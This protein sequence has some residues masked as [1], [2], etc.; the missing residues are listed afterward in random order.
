M[1]IRAIGD[2]DFP[3]RS[4]KELYGDDQLV[5]VWWRD[6]PWF[7]SASMHR[8]P[9]AMTFGDFYA[10]MIIPW[11]QSDPD[12]DENRPLEAFEWTL[13]GEP[14]TPDPNTSLADLGVG[15]KDVIGMKGSAV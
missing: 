15:H 8:A 7:C 11:A 6:N 10:Q 9:T 14:F 5:S 3:S 1:A 2:Y 4:R 12:F 13:S